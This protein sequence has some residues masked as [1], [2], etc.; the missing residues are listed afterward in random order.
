MS[1]GVELQCRVGLNCRRNFSTNDPASGSGQPSRLAPRRGPRARPA[2]GSGDVFIRAVHCGEDD[3]KKAKMHRWF[4]A[5]IALLVPIA[6]T[7]VT[8]APRACAGDAP[9]GRLGETLRVEYDDEAFGKIVAD[10]AVHD[11]HP[12][13]IPPGW[14]YNGA[15]RWR[16]Q[17]TPWRAGVTVHTIQSP[18]P[19]SLSLVFTFD[20]VTR[21]ADAY[22]SK[23][24]DAADRLEAALTNAPPGATV[25]GGVY[26]DVYREHVSNVVLLNKTSGDHL[27]QWNL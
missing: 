3:G 22:V 5:L 26:W 13:E 17:G 6:T 24:T 18:T 14:G 20:G 4:T 1:S 15:P 10:V 7:F 8:P 27:A 12:T 25:D 9:I 16:A 11:V 21:G 23:H 2:G 19:Y